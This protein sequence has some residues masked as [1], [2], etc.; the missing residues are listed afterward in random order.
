MEGEVVG[1]IARVAPRGVALLCAIGGL[2]LGGCP[3]PDN[4]YGP[5]PEPDY[6][7][8]VGAIQPILEASCSNLGCHGDP[9]RRLTLYSTAYLRAEPAVP[10]TA[11]DAD[12]LSL[13]ELGWNYDSVR[14]RLIDEEV[15]DEARLLLKCLDPAEGG[16]E[17]ADGEVVF[18]T[19]EEPGYVAL[20]DWIETGL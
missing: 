12:R 1:S 5:Y 9:D 14:A 3:G 13:A 18:A 8:F 7:E 16:I 2:L 15:A 6:D 10:G 20:R 19:P 11:L 17:H 4:P